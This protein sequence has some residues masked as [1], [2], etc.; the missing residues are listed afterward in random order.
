MLL[1]S[2]TGLHAE[3]LNEKVARNAANCLTGHIAT[4]SPMYQ[5]GNTEKYLLLIKKILGDKQ[6]IPEVKKAAEYLKASVQMMGGS[7]KEEGA[8]LNINNPAAS[9][10]GIANELPGNLLIPIATILLFRGKP[11]GITPSEIKTFCH[12]VDEILNK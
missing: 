12:G 9:R 11:R 3:T 5:S 1:I 8:W 2:Y 4:N 6:A 10:R 7:T